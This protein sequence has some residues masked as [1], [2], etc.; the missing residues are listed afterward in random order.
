VSISI[1]NYTLP[2]Q[3]FPNTA[4][5]FLKYFS[6]NTLFL[7]ARKL[8]EEQNKECKTP[9]NITVFLLNLSQINKKD[10]E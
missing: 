1:G 8:C 3:S 5:L 2:G 9:L 4:M 7:S 6:D 10:F